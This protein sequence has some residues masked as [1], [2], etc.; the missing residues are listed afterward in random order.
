MTEIAH[1]HGINVFPRNIRIYFFAVM[2]L[3]VCD[4]HFRHRGQL[5]RMSDQWKDD[6]V[7]TD[8]RSFYIVIHTHIN[9][10]HLWW[11]WDSGEKK[12][13]NNDVM[14]QCP[15]ESLVKH[16]TQKTADSSGFEHVFGLCFYPHTPTHT[17]VFSCML[18][19]GV[20]V[21]ML[22]ELSECIF[23]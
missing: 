1:F 7:R 22:S 10:T 2:Q 12:N 5:F 19:A 6:E 15:S 14:Q 3:F 20:W 16:Q 21:D 11:H 4:L 13:N 9:T 8:F 23:I 18:V 17:P